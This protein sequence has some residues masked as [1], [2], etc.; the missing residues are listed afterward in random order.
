MVSISYTYVMLYAAC[1][2]ILNKKE[3]LVVR[4][5]GIELLDFFFIVLVIYFLIGRNN[6]KDTVFNTAYEII[7]L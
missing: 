3:Y 1:L 4:T 2:R 6:L 5:S 7:V